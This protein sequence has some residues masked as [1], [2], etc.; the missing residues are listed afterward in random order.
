VPPQTVC[1]PIYYWWGYGCSTGGFVNSVTVAYKG[2][3]AGG[4]NVGGGFT[5][6]LSDTR[7]KFYTEARYTYAWSNFI[8]SEL[9]PIT[10]G[11]RYN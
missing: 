6:R 7:W 3:S 1:Q 10:F 5:I 8:H 2:A 11:L 4:L 9:I